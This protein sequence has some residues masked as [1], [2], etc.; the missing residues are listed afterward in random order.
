MFLAAADTTENWPEAVI[1]VAGIALV[2][3]VVVITVWQ[4]L[5][6]WRARM[7]GSREAAYRELAEQVAESQSR[8]TEALEHVVVELRALRGRDAASGPPE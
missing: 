1:A 7:S 6:T 8:T 4:L 3:S 5:A 2:G